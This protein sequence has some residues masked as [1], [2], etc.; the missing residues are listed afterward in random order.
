[1]IDAFDGGTSDVQYP[2]ESGDADAI[3]M[4]SIGVLA[5]RF[6]AMPAGEDP[7]Q[8][9]NKGN[10]ATQTPQTAGVDDQAGRFAKTA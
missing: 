4:R 6:A 10:Q 3:V 8:R 2:G 9:R 7:G 1:V 5:E